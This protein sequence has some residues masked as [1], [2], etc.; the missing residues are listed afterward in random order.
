MAELGKPRLAVVGCGAVAEIGLLPAARRLGM[1]PVLL[2]DRNVARAQQLAKRFGGDKVV[3]EFDDAVAKAVDAA[4]VATP[5]TVHGESCSMLLRRGIHVLVEKPMATTSQDCLAIIAAAKAGQAR[6]AVGHIFRFRN[7]NR[8]AKALVDEGTLGAIRRVDMRVG[9]PFAWPLKSDSL[10]NPKLAGGGVLMDTGVHF[11]DLILWWLGDLTLIEYVD[12]SYGGVEADC[13][14]RARVPGGGN[15]VFELSRTR[16]LRNTVIIEGEN[17]AFEIHLTKG[18]LLRAEGAARTFRDKHP[19][20]TG[21]VQQTYTQLFFEELKDWIAAIAEKREPFVNG[22]AAIPSVRFIETCYQ[23]R[24][25][26]Y[27]PWTEIGSAA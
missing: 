6:L 18:E 8:W 26:W 17:G 13:L 11:L 25:T 9:S 20:L 14:I 16:E 23:Q 5:N 12:D 4:I 19:E 10:W 3:A 24:K 7:L 1:K 21:R 15:G 2:V 27:L 22:E